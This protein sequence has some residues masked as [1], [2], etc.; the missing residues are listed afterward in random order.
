[1]SAKDTTFIRYT[2]VTRPEHYSRVAQTSVP[3]VCGQRTCTLIPAAT[4]SSAE[5]RTPETPR[6]FLCGPF[7]SRVVEK[8]SVG[9]RRTAP[10]GHEPDWMGNARTNPRV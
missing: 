10:S 7:I 4:A 8:K 2:G 9:Q 3:D 6:H 1:M 5:S